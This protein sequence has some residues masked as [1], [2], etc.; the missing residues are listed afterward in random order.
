MNITQLPRFW[1][2]KTNRCLPVPPPQATT[3]PDKSRAEPGTHPTKLWFHPG[4]SGGVHS[5]TTRCAAA[6]CDLL[7]FDENIR[8][9]ILD[10]SSVGE[11]RKQAISNGMRTLR[12]DG[13]LK[14]FD[15]KTTIDELAHVTLAY[16]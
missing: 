11:L 4:S 14:L 9:L 1:P 6:A 13:L 3:A 12:E 10:R 15:A 16:M 7:V 5:A 8:S 2:I